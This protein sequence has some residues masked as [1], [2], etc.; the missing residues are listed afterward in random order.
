MII[1]A[2]K[3]V[4]NFWFNEGNEEMWYAQSEDF[5]NEIRE[6]F[7]EAWEAARQ[8]LYM[9]GEI[10]LKGVLLKLLYSINFRETYIEAA[11]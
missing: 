9:N 7:Y 3:E 6:C 11:I 8:V 10:P 5:N 2:A 1:V 4:Y